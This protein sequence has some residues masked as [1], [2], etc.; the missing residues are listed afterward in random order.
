[1]AEPGFIQRLP[2]GATQVKV[3]PGGAHVYVT[4]ANGVRPPRCEFKDKGRW[5]ALVP[6]DRLRDFANE[7]LDAFDRAK[8]LTLLDALAPW[9][10]GQGMP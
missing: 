6:L 2:N 10:H 1:V 4:P 9:T 7:E 3:T 5:T 8:L